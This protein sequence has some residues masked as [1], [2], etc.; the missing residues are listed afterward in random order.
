MEAFVLVVAL[1]SVDFDVAVDSAEL[2]D[3][4][5]SFTTPPRPSDLEI[6]TDHIVARALNG[7]W[8]E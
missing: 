3:G 2:E 5:G 1:V 4:F 8:Y 6:I 7:S